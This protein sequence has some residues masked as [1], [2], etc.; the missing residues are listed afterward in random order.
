MIINQ[1]TQPDWNNKPR[2]ADVWLDPICDTPQHFYYGWFKKQ[3]NRFYRLL[4]NCNWCRS[5]E[6]VAYTAHYP[7]ATNL[8][9]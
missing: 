9:N 2:W 7:P 4:D 3:N 8:Q 1:S 6:G 5:Q